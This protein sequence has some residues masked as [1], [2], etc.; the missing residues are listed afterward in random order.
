MDRN[1]SRKKGSRLACAAFLFACLEGGVA[2][3]QNCAGLQVSAIPSYP[4]IDLYDS[5]NAIVPAQRLESSSSSLQNVCAE[6]ELRTLRYRIRLQDHVWWVI[7][8]QFLRVT[9]PSHLHKLPSPDAPTAG[10]VASLKGGGEGRVAYAKFLPQWETPK[11][12]TR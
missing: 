7:T 9:D 8:A 4:L 5:P 3:G 2:N 12:A 10:T 6:E 1:G 11:L